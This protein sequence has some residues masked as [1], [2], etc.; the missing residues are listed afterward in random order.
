MAEQVQHPMGYEVRE[1]R[2]HAPPRRPRLAPDHAQRQRHV[3][4][5]AG[6]QGREGEDIGRLHLAPMI[7][8]QPLHLQIP[9]QQ[10]RHGAAFG[11]GPALGEGGRRGTPRDLLHPWHGGAPGRVLYHHLD[12]EIP[13]L[14]GRLVIQPGPVAE[15]VAVAGMPGPGLVA[16]SP[17]DREARRV[18]GSQEKPGG[19]ATSPVY[20][21]PGGFTTGPSDEK[22]GGF[23]TGRATAHLCPTP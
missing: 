22:P 12:V 21:R 3:A 11:R 13:A 20:G 6:M 7:A 8:V 1:M 2:H 4:G 23:T 16:T 19:I 10:H 14:A 18:A 17:A 15:G 9:G 5:H